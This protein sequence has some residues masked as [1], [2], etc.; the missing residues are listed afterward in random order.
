MIDPEVLLVVTL[1]MLVPE[2]KWYDSF[3]TYDSFHTY[4]VFNISCMNTISMWLKVTELAIAKYHF[5]NNMEVILHE[6]NPL[7]TVWKH[8]VCVKYKLYSS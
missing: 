3:Y 6:P 7:R 4:F 8:T 2:W 5:S 1:P